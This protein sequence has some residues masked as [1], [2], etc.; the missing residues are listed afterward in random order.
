IQFLDETYLFGVG[1]RS[2]TAILSL[3]NISKVT[4]VSVVREFELPGTWSDT[5]MRFSTNSSPRSDVYQTSDALFYTAPETRV[6]AISSIPTVISRSGYYPV[7]WLFLK[8]TYFRYPSRK[9]GF[10]IL[11]RQWGQYCIIKEI[12]TT[13]GA[14]RGPYVV[15]TKVFYV[16]NAPA[17]TSRNHGHSR[18]ARLRVID[19]SPFSESVEPP[20]G[21]SSIGPRSNLIP[22][23]SSRS[24]PSSSVDGLPIK[25]ANATEDNVVLFLEARQGYQSVNILTFGAPVSGSSRMR[26]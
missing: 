22:T 5:T 2:G 17:Q 24:I 16:E 3:Y 4:S 10:R 14:I 7:N 11:W 19:F 1:S 9:D 8:E 13:P 12:E 26:R 20:R 23:E 21:W 18:S 15:G 6:L 25:D